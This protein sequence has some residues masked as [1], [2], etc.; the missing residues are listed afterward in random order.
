[1]NN[2]RSLVLTLILAFP[3]YPYGKSDIIRGKII[4]SETNVFYL[5]PI[6]TQ[7]KVLMG[8]H[9]NGGRFNIEFIL[10]HCIAICYSDNK[11]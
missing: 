5:L 7:S 4:D 2:I 3:I 8:E 10:S 6:F 11:Y 1:M 9:L